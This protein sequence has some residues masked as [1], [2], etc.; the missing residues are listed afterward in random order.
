MTLKTRL[1]I[2]LGL[3]T[4]IIIGLIAGGYFTLS[5]MRGYTDMLVTDHLQPTRN[6]KLVADAYAVAIVDN[7][8]KTRAG[9]VDWPQSLKVLT[10]AEQLIDTTW[11]A[12][13]NRSKP[14]EDDAA[15]ANVVA[16][17]ENATGAMKTLHGIIAAKD[18]DALVTF[19]EHQL[20][21]AID[22]I[23]KAISDEIALLET[24]AIGDL[25]E[26]S[27]FDDM[28]TL[29]MLIA[30]AVAI[31]A[32]G[33]GTYVIIRS[34]ADRLQRLQRAVS[35]VASGA[36]E[37]AIPF[38]DRRDEIGLMATAAEVFRHNSLELRTISARDATERA[39][40]EQQRRMMMGELQASF[41]SAVNAA[42]AGDLTARVAANFADAELNGLAADVNALLEAV[43]GGIGATAVVLSALATAD[44]TP[45]VTGDFGGAFARLRDD[46][47]AVAEK[48]TEIVGELRVTSQSLRSATGEI[49]AG[50]NDLSER[51]TRQAATIEETSA[52]MEQ[53]ASTVAGN[54]L[55]ADGASQQAELAANGAHQSGEAMR[56]AS[57]AMDRITASSSEIAN[58]ISMIDDI[59]FQT[60]LLALNASVEA[61]RAGD[62]GKGFA[63]VAQE[64]RRL[65]QSAAVSSGEVKTLIARSEQQVGAG[66]SLVKSAATSLEAVLGTVRQNAEAMRE[67]A[68]AS[69]QQS[70]AINE[71]TVAVRQLDEMTQH[72]AALVEETNAA[73]EQ[74]E[75][76]AVA[77]DT[78]I[79]VFRV[80]PVSARGGSAG[81]AA[82]LRNKYR[83]AA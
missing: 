68:S 66:T 18:H 57:E 46:T 48:M 29:G 55:S 43:E 2:S 19:A 7:V 39:E 37:D 58:I 59:A 9:T 56:K 34:V 30:G 74:T 76:Q 69:R 51:T 70:S 81:R 31:A 21:P 5:V 15:Q 49:L 38:T 12:E 1:T 82:S 24:N 53:L 72:N 54:A 71:I 78:L 47:N 52:S 79:S 62:A 25:K 11:S 42:S 36:L 41:G 20:Y 83:V 13:L 6:L 80:D 10:E 27:A 64:V 26:A 50:A 67:I 16:A 63:V 23:S 4:T 22:P 17:I 61:A 28:V 73:I 40:R 60:N 45:R 8:H 44:L 32:L 35:D 33:Y 14:A 77:L 3:L 75:T 65:A